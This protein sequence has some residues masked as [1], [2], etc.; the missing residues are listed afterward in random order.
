[1]DQPPLIYLHGFASSPGSAKATFF[2]SRLEAAGVSMVVPDLN[3]GDFDGLTITSM[4]D[5]VA[6]IHREMG[7]P[8][9]LVGSSMGALVAS[10]HAARHG[11]VRKMVLM[12]PAFGFLERWK[13]DLG[14]EGVRRWRERG[15]LPVHHYQ[16]DEE[17]SLKPDI[18]DDASRHTLDRL[19][20]LAMP[21]LVIHGSRDDVVPPSGSAEFCA[22]HSSATLHVLDADH[23]LGEVMEEIWELMS[24]FLLE[25]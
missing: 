9:D 18:L 20:G 15:H 11:K 10:H 16:Y 22:S 2:R 12:A 3:C 1:M 8:V 19:D 5:L 17:R 13:E 23:G 24:E 25:P 4:L 21:M 7:S 6:G 14:P